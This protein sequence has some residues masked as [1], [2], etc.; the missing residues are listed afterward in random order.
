M[1]EIESVPPVESR[2]AVILVLED[3][4]I[5]HLGHFVDYL[6][7][8]DILAVDLAVD[9]LFLIRQENI[10]ASVL[11]HQHLLLQY[12]EGIFHP[13]LQLN[14]V[15]V[16]IADHEA[17]DIVHIRLDFQ[18]ILDHEQC[19]EH[20]N[21]KDAALFMFG[22]DLRI[23]IGAQDHTPVTMV[24]EILQ[25]IIK[26]MERYNDAHLFIFQSCGRLFK[27][28]QHGTLTFRQM[29][30]GST[31]RTDGCQN[32]GKQ[33]K[34][35][36]NKRVYFRKVLCSGIEL[37]L[38][39]VIKDD[40][41]LDDRRFLLIQKAQRL[42]C[43]I[44]LVE[45]PLLN[46]RIH[47]RRRQRQPGIESTLD[48]GEV[49]SLHFRDGID[50]L[51]A[52]HDDPRL[53]LA[54]LTQL[55][56]Y[57]LQVEHQF[58]VLADI[59]PDLVNEK[60]HVMVLALG[61]DVGFH[62]FGKILNADLIRLR[63]LLAPV[64]RCMF[65]HEVHVRQNIDNGI[66]DEV[67]F[68]TVLLPGLAILV[69]KSLFELFHPSGFSELLLQIRQ[70]RQGAAVSLHLIEH[71]K[72]NVD[73]GVLVL[74]AAGIA[75]G[76]NIEKDHV[77]RRLGCEPDI[78]Q[79]HRI[80]DLLVLCEIIQS[81]A[82]ADLP[83]L[84]KVRKDL[85]EVRFTAAEET[86]DPYAHLRGRAENSLLV[87]SEEI[88]EM[89]LQLLC[90]N[91]FFQLLGNVGLFAL[92]HYYDALNITV[93]WLY[94]HVLELH[95]FPPFFERGTVPRSILLYEPERSVIVVIFDLI[96]QD[97]LLFVICAG[98]EH[99]HRHSHKRLMKVVQHLM[100]AEDRIALPDPRQKHNGVFR[101]M[102]PDILHDI[103]VVIVDLHGT[104]YCLRDPVQSAPLFEPVALLKEVFFLQIV[105]DDVVQIEN[106]QLKSVN[107]F[108]ILFLQV[109]HPLTHFQLVFRRIVEHPVIDFVRPAAALPERR[110]FDRGFHLIQSFLY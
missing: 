46:D 75:L 32:T 20:V 56:R 52:G 88:C 59:L 6:R 102:I 86:G 34:L 82:V 104:V 40:Q 79:H 54:L 63:C 96:E 74:L 28:R 24:Q 43:R 15:I 73:D 65:A 13:A 38:H 108:L 91:V 93:D 67:E 103:A 76:I 9:L 4:L 35:V 1:V 77:G 37:L 89:L 51:L 17:G 53:A 8:L 101:R 21:D 39:A 70:V 72:E 97:E 23:V 10:Y 99:D 95:G 78:R 7:H 33:V 81:R 71:A 48:L 50:V 41:V 12:L 109:L 100:R 11:L 14:A 61:I 2:V 80:R 25:C 26:Q 3:I 55:F 58:G 84:Q 87:G 85:K 16:D 47:V 45:D 44:G 19:L 29:F 30:A 5:D 62:S 22:I 64:A 31:V 90:N 18:D 107:T 83:V 27:Q 36:R 68:M 57:R 49:I 110:L 69:L 66:L 98:K 92:S 94:E 42:R 60:Y 105:H 106:N